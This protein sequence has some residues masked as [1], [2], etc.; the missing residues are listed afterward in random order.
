MKKWIAF[1]LV[2]VLAFVFVGC[3][4][5]VDDGK[6]PGG[7]G[8]VAVAGLTISGA[9]TENLKA[10]DT[11]Q[12]TATVTPTDA[13]DKTVQW[14]SKN[15]SVATVDQNGLVTAQTVDQTS[16]TEIVC[17]SKDNPRISKSVNITV[18]VPVVYDP[19]VSVTLSGTKAEVAVSHYITLEAIVSPS[20]ASQE[21]LW[22]SSDDTIATVANGK[23]TGVAEGTVTITVTVVADETLTDT[24][25]VTIVKDEVVGPGNPVDP[26]DV[27]ITGETSVFEGKYILLTASVLPA[28]VSQNVVWSVDDET[29]ASITYEGVLTGL[30]AGTV[31]VTAASAKDMSVMKVFKVT[32]KEPLPPVTIPNMNGYVLKIMTAPH[33]P[34]EHDPFLDGYVALDKMA[35]QEAWLEVERQFNVDLQVVP[36]PDTAPWGSPRINYLN[37][38]AA[39]GQAETDVFVSTTDWL[40]VLADGNSIVDTSAY[41][42]EFGNNSMNSAMKGAS[43]YHG[44]LYALPTDSVATINVDK[45]LFFNVA[46][47]ESYSLE[48]PA[49]LFNEGN[50][51]YSKFA[52]YVKN[53]A[54]VLGEGKTVL[55]GKPAY[56]YTGMV[57][58]AGVKLADTITLQMNFDNPYAVQA[59]SILRDLYVTTGW[60]TNAWDAA[61]TTFNEGNSLF[62]AGEYWFV[63][64][65]NRWPATL[66]NADGTSRFGYVPYPYP[67]N[68]QKADTRTVGAGGACYMMAAGRPYTLGVTA[69]DVYQAFTTMMLWTE[70]N[71]RKD[72]EFDEETKMRQSASAKLDD[73]DSV[74]AL[75]YFT[76][77]KVVFDPLFGLLDVSSNIGTA[78]DQII[79]D[80]ADYSQVMD[81][82][83]PL[84][85][86]K[87][88]D[89][90]S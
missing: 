71:M 47:L 84:Y 77:D 45:G 48:N 12:L 27:V 49:K 40:K 90:Y 63:K 1:M 59:A 68:M 4:D 78:M 38:K 52:E 34:H 60:G 85:L 55:S 3:K 65:D 21:V 30:K 50:W 51:T 44:A 20:S 37:E 42:E 62:Q 53:A 10:G 80:G 83:K 15:T 17:T 67:D 26:E 7:D 5:K 74:T 16:S 79:R 35:K 66:W 28:G 58:A 14:T 6:T 29:V 88:Q 72:P 24:F 82:I 69:K 70:D 36:F 41:Y 18:E 57:N 25:P 75:V 73:A 87:M 19:P 64:T 23:V 32:V 13:T 81:G 31:Y 8:K 76:R 2:F 54:S 89:L 46:L 11:V 33:V 22:A 43:T 9:P 61:V 56:Y 86:T 39:L